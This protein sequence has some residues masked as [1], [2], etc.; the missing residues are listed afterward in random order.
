MISPLL[1]PSRFSSPP[2]KRHSKHRRPQ[3]HMRA[4]VRK[5]TA[6]FTRESLCPK[7]STK[8]VRKALAEADKGRLG[9]AESLLNKM[10]SREILSNEVVFQILCEGYITNKKMNKLDHLMDTMHAI[11]V[12]P[13]L[14]VYAKLMKGHVAKGDMAKAE[15]VLDSM[16]SAKLFQQLHDRV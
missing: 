4:L 12:T 1:F 16:V 5:V 8:W 14:S 11:K 6:F 7:E 2:G 13:P 15:Q 3:L 10:I 9:Q